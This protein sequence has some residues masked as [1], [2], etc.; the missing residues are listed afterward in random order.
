MA[1]RLTLSFD[2][3]PTPAVTAEVL[4]LLAARG[5]KT[6]FFVVG[7]KLVADGARELVGRAK[8]EGHWTGNHTF[9]H[10]VPLGE[11]V[12]PNH[13]ET[14]I[15]HMQTTLGSLATYPLLFRPFGRGG[16]LGPH[17][18]SRAATEYLIEHRYTCVLWNCV[19]GDWRD[20]EGWVETCLA[21]MERLIWPLVVLHDVPDAS[22]ARLPDFLDR[23]AAKGVAF[24]QDF[25]PDCVLLDRGRA[26]AP[27]EPFVTT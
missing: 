23:V 15:G 12:D 3:G 19:P 10:S 27:I 11:Q 6:T 9:T 8:R 7:R 20:P 14:E 25:P 22:L 26:T 24:R 4:D 17:L 18:L 2:N 21:E 5:I 1:D 13:V 16:A